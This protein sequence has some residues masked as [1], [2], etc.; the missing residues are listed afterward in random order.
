MPTDAFDGPSHV[1]NT[2]GTQSYRRDLTG[3]EGLADTHRIMIRSSALGLF[4]TF[5]RSLLR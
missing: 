3:G 1:Q 2:Y 4:G 5:C